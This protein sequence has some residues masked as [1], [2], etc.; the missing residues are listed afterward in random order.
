MTPT[1]T[2]VLFDLDGTLADTAP[3]LQYALNQVLTEQGLPP[4]PLG[5]VRP[6][7]SHGAIAMLRLAYPDAQEETLLPLRNRFIDRYRAC[8][9]RQTTL[10]PG[11]LN[12]LGALEARGIVWGIV[13]NKLAELTEPLLH[14]LGL[15][16]RA[17]CVVSGDTT[18]FAKPH[19]APLLHA[20]EL[21]GCEPAAAIYVGDSSR[22]VE[23]ARRAG[24]RVVVAGY[25]YMDGVDTAKQWAA[26]HVIG[27]PMELLAWVGLGAGNN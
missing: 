4:L 26:D 17:A 1:P 19:P 25:G 21:L 23:A 20:C 13:T 8:L 7:A 5:E 18:A 11:T 6:A 24:M 3:D 27:E 14:T 12:L 9:D 16:Q 2:H 10:F 22:D 15:L